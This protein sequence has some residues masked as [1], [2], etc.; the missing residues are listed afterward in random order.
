MT[1]WVKQLTQKTVLNI[2]ISIFIGQHKSINPLI[3]S[4]TIPY[5]VYDISFKMLINN[6]IC[7]LIR[8]YLY[9]YFL[10]TCRRGCAIM[11]YHKAVGRY[12]HTIGRSQSD[13]EF[14]QA[15]TV[16]PIFTYLIHIDFLIIQYTSIY[17]VDLSNM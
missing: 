8:D 13:F 14:G 9:F 2:I 4:Y 3:V 16:K 15:T 5:D 12:D 7:K 17:L 1:Q 10:N 11:Y 6:A